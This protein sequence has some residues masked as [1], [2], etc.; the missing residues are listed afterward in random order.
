[1]QINKLT[2]TDDEIKTNLKNNLQEKSWNENQISKTRS[3]GKYFY[4][5]FPL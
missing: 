3:S 5:S 1:M 2:N 4:S